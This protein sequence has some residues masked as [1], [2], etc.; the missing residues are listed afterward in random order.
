MSQIISV[1]VPD[2]TAERL[3][4][5]ARR[6]GNGMTRTKAVVL[7]LEEALSEA[8]FACIEYRDSPLG[9]QPYIQGTG[10]TVWEMVMIGRSYDFEAERMA[11]EYHYPVASV[12]A[13]FHFYESHTKEI[14]QAI[15]DNN[16]GYEA[17]KRRLPQG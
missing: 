7:L 12:H 4:R 17:M 9:R 5:F 1:R 14:D 2:Q 6:Q 8:E 16:T 11:Q 13:A 10:L 15:E 3:E